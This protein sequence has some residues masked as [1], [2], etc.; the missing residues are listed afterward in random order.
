[1]ITVG[2]FSR[3]LSIVQRAGGERGLLNLGARFRGLVVRRQTQVTVPLLVFDLYGLSENL[4]SMHFE[5]RKMA[6]IL[7]ACDQN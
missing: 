5:D 3:C 1:V 6:C 7:F 4:Y 2:R